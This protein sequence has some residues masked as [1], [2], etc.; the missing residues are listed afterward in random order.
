MNQRSQNHHLILELFEVWLATVLTSGIL[1][2]LEEK[3]L[4]QVLR[5]RRKLTWNNWESI[6]PGG[7]ELIL[8]QG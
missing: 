1:K 3:I 7:S 4:L 2:E 6:E 8:K 5:I